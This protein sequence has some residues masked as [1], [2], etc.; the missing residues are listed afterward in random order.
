MSLNPITSPW[1]RPIHPP[2]IRSNPPN[3]RNDLPNIRNIP[4]PP[5]IIRSVPERLANNA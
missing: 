3:I 4:S 1:G 5:D 2:N